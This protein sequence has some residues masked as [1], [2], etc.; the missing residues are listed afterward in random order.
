MSKASMTWREIVNLG[1]KKYRLANILNWLG[2]QFSRLRFHKTGL[3]F[4]RIALMID[5]L[6]PVFKNNY[7]HYLERYYSQLNCITDIS[8][9]VITVKD[10]CETNHQ[11]LFVL[12][13]NQRDNLNKPQII[14][15]D[16]YKGPTLYEG[17]I[18]LPDIYLA[19]LTNTL[20]F[21]G[22]DLIVVNDTQP[23]YDEV[24]LDY[25]NQYNCKISLIVSRKGQQ[26]KIKY[27]DQSVVCLDKAIHF[28]KSYSRNYFHWLIEC[29]PRMMI[30]NQF[31]TLQDV[32][33]IIDAALPLQ[34]LEALRLINNDRLLIQLPLNQAC[35]VEKLF[36]PSSLSIINDN[37]K[38]P[39]QYDKDI[40]Y[41]PMAINFVRNFF[42][43]K[44][45]D[46][47]LAPSK[48]LYVS[49][50]KS[51]YRRLINA[52]QVEAVMLER[53]F[54]IV[55]PENL[56]FVEQ[57]KL[58]SQA[59]VIVGPSG[60]GLANL[61]FAP[62]ACKVYVLISDD[63]QMNLNIFH[64]VAQAIGIDLNYILGKAVPFTHYVSFHK[65]YRIDIDLLKRIF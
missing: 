21:A 28:V 2:V 34:Q 38:A 13:T 50:G 44:I 20:F 47:S 40:L 39:L 32:P 16:L 36:Y 31:E 60:A 52:K 9:S 25:E 46:K 57:V 41:S 48:K 19:E 15:P 53:G 26:I 58:F 45:G 7:R 33:L 6:H 11:P 22:T 37:Y 43:E 17:Q 27:S 61:L 65:D 23:L 54:E 14:N 5:P 29:L 56:S 4:I 18:K 35:K 49:R 8:G 12:Q 30:I 10:W 55:C 64:G 62:Q 1:Y 59:S 51:P 3:S 42:L 24:A 63:K